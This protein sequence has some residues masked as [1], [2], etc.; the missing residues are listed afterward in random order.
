MRK[1]DP[2]I[3]EKTKRRYRSIEQELFIFPFEGTGMGQDRKVWT[4]GPPNETQAKSCRI[5]AHF[6]VNMTGS[7]GKRRL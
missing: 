1:D 3:M 5:D 2:L 7:D 4:S 6:M